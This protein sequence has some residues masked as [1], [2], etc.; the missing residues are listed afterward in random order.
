MAH[1]IKCEH[2]FETY[3]DSCLKGAD[4]NEGKSVVF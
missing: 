4:L 3:Q 2:D 1:L